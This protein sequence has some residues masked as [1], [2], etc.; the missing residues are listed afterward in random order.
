MTNESSTI[1]DRLGAWAGVG[2]VVSLGIGYA[3]ALTFKT[4]LYSTDG[5]FARE[6]LAERMKWE[7]VTF[8]RLLGGTLVLWFMGTLAGRLRQAE[9]EPARLSSAA[10]GLGVVWAGVWLLSGLFNSAAIRLAADFANP[11]GARVA[12]VLADQAPRTL[13]GCIVFALSLAT[14]LISRRTRA[15]P[16]SFT[17]ATTALAPLLVILALIDWYASRPNEV[18]IGHAIVGLALLWTAAASVLLIGRSRG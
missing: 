5:D 13:T 12:G 1:W 9:G 14:A 15:F 6:L 4:N 17:Y 8:V 10:F 11:S 16:A 7:W 18:G 3:I 2:A